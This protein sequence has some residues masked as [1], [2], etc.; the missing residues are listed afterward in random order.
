MDIIMMELINKILIKIIL[1]IPKQGLENLLTILQQ[2]Q[3]E[4][5]YNKILNENEY[6]E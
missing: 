1:I 5:S 3:A 4:C 2:L 6:E